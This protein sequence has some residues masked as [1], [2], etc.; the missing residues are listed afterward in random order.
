MLQRHRKE[1]QECSE[2]TVCATLDILSI[3]FL[4]HHVQDNVMDIVFSSYSLVNDK[5][6]ALAIHIRFTIELSFFQKGIYSQCQII[7][8]NYKFT[9][10]IFYSLRNIYKNYVK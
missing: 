4:H 2:K 9:K 1:N 8:I 10:F 3:H 5:S 6:G 7:F